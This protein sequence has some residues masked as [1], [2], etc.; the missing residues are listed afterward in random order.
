MKA[1]STTDIYFVRVKS[2]TYEYGP[3]AHNTCE[4]ENFDGAWRS[5]VSV[6]KSI[7]HKVEHASRFGSLRYVRLSKGRLV[8][9]LF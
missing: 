5:R 2:A 4:L 8:T 9:E 1:F 3:G 6:A 7:A